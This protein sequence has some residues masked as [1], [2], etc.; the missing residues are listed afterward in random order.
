MGWRILKM[1]LLGTRRVTTT[2]EQRWETSKLK[3]GKHKHDLVSFLTL[4]GTR[5]LPGPS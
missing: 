4:T 1:F 2:N 5:I 3:R